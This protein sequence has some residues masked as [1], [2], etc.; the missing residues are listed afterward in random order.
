VNVV[1][2]LAIPLER[3]TEL[4]ERLHFRRQVE[5]AVVDG[6]IERLDAE[7]I[8][9]RE[10]HVIALVPD[11][12]RKLAAKLVDRPGTSILVQVQRDFAVGSRSEGV[13]AALQLAADAFEIVKLPVRDD[14]K[15]LVF[16]RDGLITGRQVDDA[17]PR[18]AESGAPVLIDPNALRVGSAMLKPPG[19]PVERLG[20]HSAS[21][22]Y[23]RYDAAHL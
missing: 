9:C 10:Q 15:P 18:V 17:E 12:I 1:E 19:R 6:V 4:H 2:R 13:P 5:G 23:C 22:R 8:A 3:N 20:R 21:A 11:G 16:V 14:V 7:A